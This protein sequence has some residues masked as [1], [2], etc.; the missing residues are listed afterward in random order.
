MS[1]KPRIGISVGDINGIGPEVIVKTFSDP[2]MMELCTPVIF[3]SAKLMTAARKQVT[4]APFSF[5]VTKDFTALDEVGVNVFSCWEE[6]VQLQPGKLTD[7]GGKYA[8]RSFM[9]GTQCLKDG[10]I[11][12]LVTAPINKSNTQL[13]DFPYTGHTPYLKST[14]GAKD[15]VMLLFTNELRVALATEHVPLEKV[16]QTITRDLLQTKLAILRDTLIKDFGIDRP[17]IAVL[18]LNPH[19]GDEGQIGREELDV[20]KPLLEQLQG[21]GQLVYGPYSP[22]A[23][24]ARRQYT[25]FDAVLA[26][27]HDQGLIPFKTI[28]AG[29]G[30]NYTAGLPAIRT[31]PDHGTA[32]DIAGQDKADPSS[33]REAVF[34]AIDIW[35][36]R[37]GYAEATA[38]PLQRGK[39][40]KERY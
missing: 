25:E 9:V 22:D 5:L 16:S 40:Q 13:Q 2:R 4:D 19:A 21:A 26:M 32:F 11:D 17:K 29:E 15:V 12:A 8:V 6:D 31:S 18:G 14:F 1:N 38:R 28:A 34:A 36:N 27:Y 24:F 33:F 10:Q 23:F 20:I 30:I 7:V 39:M 37:N 3:A 35:R